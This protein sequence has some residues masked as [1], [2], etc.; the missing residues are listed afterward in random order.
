M[1]CALLI[2]VGSPPIIIA[3]SWY[4]RNV[5]GMSLSGKL[6]IFHKR[7]LNKN[8]EEERRR[9]GEK[10]RRNRRKKGGTG[11]RRQAG[12]HRGE[13]RRGGMK[14]QGGTGWQ[15]EKPA[16][17]AHTT[18]PTD[19]SQGQIRVFQSHHE[20]ASHQALHPLSFTYIKHT[21][22]CTF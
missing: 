19:A 2:F 8:K 3:H 20:L 9:R 14:S 5:Y 7:S 13:E 17:E 6:P 12:R 21:N 15:E 22:T 1:A 11:E 16:T 10:E 4:T 18:K